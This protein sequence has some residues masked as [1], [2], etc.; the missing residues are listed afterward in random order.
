MLGVPGGVIG[1]RSESA[2]G[3]SL[4][5]VGVILDFD[6]VNVWAWADASPSRF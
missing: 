2:L 5:S 1:T 4:K 6:G 3:V